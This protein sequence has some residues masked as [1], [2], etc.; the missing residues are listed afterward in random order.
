M[1]EPVPDTL[2]LLCRPGFEKDCAERGMEV[3]MARFS[4]TRYF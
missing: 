2:V 3:F 4:K 1:S